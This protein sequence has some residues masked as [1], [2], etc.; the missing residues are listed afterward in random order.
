[1]QSTLSYK[2][3]NIRGIRINVIRELDASKS[4]LQG[5]SLSEA[6]KGGRLAGG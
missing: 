3:K 2:L 6:V 1:M 5:D 4:V